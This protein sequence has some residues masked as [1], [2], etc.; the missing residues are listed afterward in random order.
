MTL[1]SVVM[2]SIY[3]IIEYCGGIMD[4]YILISV[5]LK[6]A[7]ARTDCY[8]R[9]SFANVFSCMVFKHGVR[10]FL[11]LEN[12]MDLLKRPVSIT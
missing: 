4:I 7:S 11:M 2:G 5:P 9:V 12:N 1:L 10:F 3:D 8:Q 6:R